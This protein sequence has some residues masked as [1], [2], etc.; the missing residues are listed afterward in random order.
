MSVKSTKLIETLIKTLTDDIEAI[1]EQ[2]KASETSDP[3]VVATLQST[4]KRLI[5][6]REGIV[7]AS[8]LLMEN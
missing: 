4:Q 8:N 7:K 2:I 6:A 1:E 5:A 3:L